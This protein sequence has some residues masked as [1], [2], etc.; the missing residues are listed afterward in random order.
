VRSLADRVLVMYLGQVVEE[1]GTD[2]LFT[3]PRHPYTRALMAASPLPDPARAR[4]RTRTPISG[5]VPSPLNPPR[6]CR[7]HPRC[8][9]VID[10]CRSEAPVLRDFGGLRTA[11]HRAEE[12]AA[13]RPPIPAP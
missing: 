12:A 13:A 2:A 10:R 3:L 11:C 1:G 4:A 6:G 8:P 7:F 9:L 5:E